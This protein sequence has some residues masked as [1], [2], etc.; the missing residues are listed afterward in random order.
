MITLLAADFTGRRFLRT[1]YIAFKKIIKTLHNIDVYD[2]V[3]E[4]CGAIEAIFEAK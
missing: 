2:E 3:Y 4:F 1:S